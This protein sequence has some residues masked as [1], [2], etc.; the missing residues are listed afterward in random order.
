MRFLP[1]E[2]RTIE[3]V[4]QIQNPKVARDPEDG[5]GEDDRRQS[6]A[7]LTTTNQV[8]YLTGI[9]F[10]FGEI[11]QRVKIRIED[12][13]MM[14]TG[15]LYAIDGESLELPDATM[16][17]APIHRAIGYQ[18]DA[19]R[20]V[21]IYCKTKKT[22]E[23]YV[24]FGCIEEFRPEVEAPPRVEASVAS[25]EKPELPTV[26]SLGKEPRKRGRRRRPAFADELGRI[27]SLKTAGLD[28]DVDMQF[29]IAY[30]RES[31][32][33]IYRKMKKG[34]FPPSQKRGGS[35]FWRMSVIERY[36]LGQWVAETDLNPMAGN[37]SQVVAHTPSDSPK[38]AN[39]GAHGEMTDSAAT[40]TVAGTDSGI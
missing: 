14:G 35:V 25:Q 13:R 22:D 5:D 7:D 27:D 34:Q 19:S 39:D 24:F 15:A 4:G 9:F 8:P 26:E 18:Y 1:S 29:L 31:R 6:T 40:L 30:L 2:S 23:Q 11:T 12:K 32:P 37:I 10:G 28:P 36:R 21:R 3:P 38:P 33:T 20:D 16:L 17:P